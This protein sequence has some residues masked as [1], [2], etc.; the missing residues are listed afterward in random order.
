MDTLLSPAAVRRAVT[1]ALAPGR[2]AVAPAV[3]LD[4]PPE[5]AREI[6]WELFHGRLLGDHQTRRRQAFHCWEVFVLDE[7]GERGPLLAVLFDPAAPCLH[8]TRSVHSY[9][10]EGYDAGDN[11]F[12][13]RE[14]QRWLRELVATIDLPRCPDA[15]A[16]AHALEQALFRAVVGLSRLPLTSLEAP[17]PAFTLGKLGY[18]PSLPASAAALPVSADLLAR[19][20]PARGLE[21]IKLLELLLRGEPNRTALAQA[22]MQRPAAEFATLLQAVFDEAALSPWTD[23]V[24]RTLA[25]LQLLTPPGW[26]TVT[27]HV[28]LLGALLRRIGRHLT[29][30][31]LVTFHHRGANY[32]DALLLDAVLKE[33][34]RLAAAQPELFTTAD[35]AI[36]RRRALRQGWLLRCRYE[37]HPVPAL[38]TSPGENQRVLPAAFPHLDDEAILDP[39]RRTKQLFVDDPIAARFTPE[40]QALLA[41]SI[42]DLEQPAEL[43]ELGLALLLD[44][45]LGTGRH[46]TEPDRTVLLSYLAFSATVAEER[47]RLLVRLGMV[48]ALAVYQAA[49]AALAREGVPVQR[50]ALPARAGVP[51]LQDA[52]RIAPDFVLRATTRRSAEDFLRQYDLAP[53]AAVLPLDWL[54]AGRPVLIV[55]GGAIADQPATALTIL[56]AAGQRR[57]ELDYEPQAGYAA[58]GTWECPAQGLRLVRTWEETAGGWQERRWDGAEVRVRGQCQG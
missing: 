53:L 19:A 57:L 29:A 28:D 22:W 13:S 10:W 52:F 38:P 50:Q 4:F 27:A 12:R 23:F 18:F 36:L 45:P 14:V 47:L 24:E 2:F 5:T 54:Y 1:T 37:G 21:L 25:F 17:L 3:Q 11:V 26:L 8:V 58:I 51:S 46:P 33:Y 39:T 31:D 20:A 40:L 44:R 48:P 35:G 55:G 16:L 41:A 43:R 32:P 56:D 9:V 34:L 7:S 30:F 6:T 42:R 15:A 49:L